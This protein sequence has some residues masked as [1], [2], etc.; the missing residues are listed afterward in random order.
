MSF[1]VSFLTLFLAEL[2]DKTQ[3]LGMH[4]ASKYTTW[5]VLVGISGSILLLKLIQTLLGNQLVGILPIIYLKPVV[6]VV[7]IL[8]GIFMYFSKEKKGAKKKEP[9]NLNLFFVILIAYFFAELG[10][11]SEISTIALAANYNSFWGVW[12]GSSAGMILADFLGIGLMHVLKR[13]LSENTLR[14]VSSL[15]FIVLGAVIL[16]QSL[17]NLL[18]VI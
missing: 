11:K 13:K 4:F 5:K 1:I 10:D 2:G 9:A 17:G 12:L 8:C 7:F 14:Y 18:S 3:L 6:G 15:F 16:F